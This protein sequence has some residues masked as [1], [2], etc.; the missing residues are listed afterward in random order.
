MPDGH[1]EQPL[2]ERFAGA[3]LID[4]AQPLEQGMPVSPNHPGYKL[5]L[6]RRHGDMVRAD[7][8]S[9]SNEMMLLGGHTGTHI[10]ALCHVSH[11]GKLFGGQDAAA[12]QTGG[13]FNVHGV[14]SIP[15]IFWRGV[16][17]DIAG[18]HGVDVLAPGT[19]ITASDLER[20]ADRQ[21]VDVK[22][23]D[24]VL[25]RSGWP[26]HWKDVDTFVGHHHGVPGPDESAAEWL[27][28]RKIRLTGAE[29]IAYECI[30][31]ERGHALLPVHR[32]LLVE[33]GIHIIEVL[34]LTELATQGIS[35][36]LF[37]VTPLKVV[38]ATGVPIRPVAVVG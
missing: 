38:G 6:Q 14:E 19:P 2:W 28:N 20:A 26:T 33:Q 25:I 36:F 16:M 37:V 1:A 4:L 15:L 13:R 27:I 29:T 9:A 5:A 18:L 12:A 31:P 24:A 3:R 8:G 35:E 17:L 7:G 34:N 30:Y 10:D 23:G 21:G 11:Q 32:M 22:P